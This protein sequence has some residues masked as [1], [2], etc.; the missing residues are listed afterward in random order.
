[1]IKSYTIASGE[2]D[3]C[4]DILFESSLRADMEATFRNMKAFSFIWDGEDAK[5][6]TNVEEI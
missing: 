3:I 4:T 2:E 5:S 1:M 6:I